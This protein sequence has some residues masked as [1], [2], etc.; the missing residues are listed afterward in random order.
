MLSGQAANKIGFDRC[1]QPK[2]V[3][4]DVAG[5]M[6][7]VHIAFK[8]LSLLNCQQMAFLTIVSGEEFSQNIC[9]RTLLTKLIT[10]L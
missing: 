6:L 3:L 1:C 5:E 2:L 9:D 7:Q 10:I 4:I 8:N